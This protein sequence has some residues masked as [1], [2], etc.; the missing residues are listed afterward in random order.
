[1]RLIIWQCRTIGYKESK[2]TGPALASISIKTLISGYE[3]AWGITGSV[4]NED[5]RLGFQ[6]GLP[7]SYWWEQ[8]GSCGPST[9]GKPLL[10]LLAPEPRHHHTPV[11]MVTYL[12]PCPSPCL[13][14]FQTQVLQGCIW[15]VDI[16]WKQ[17][18]KKGFVLPTSSTRR[19]T[20]S[21]LGWML[22]APTHH[23]CHIQFDGLTNIHS[24]NT[25]M[26]DNAYHV[27]K[28]TLS[29]TTGGNFG[30]I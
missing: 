29:H 17:D 21:Q 2:L 14:Q 25:Q 23:F 28:W 15:F 13:T 9:L 11:S 24:T 27:W 1:M 30:S 7:E 12:V 8:K 20:R 6:Q 3:T 5:S 16:S 10:R 18:W 4:Q 22:N 19:H 26:I